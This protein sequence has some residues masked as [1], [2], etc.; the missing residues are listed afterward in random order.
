MLGGN[1]RQFGVVQQ[2]NH[3]GDV[4]AALHGAQQFDGARLADQ[5]GAGFALGDGREETGLDVSGLIHTGR[6]AVGDQ[7]NQEGFF[8]SRWVF[9]QL[10]Q[11]CGLFGVQ[12]LGHDA[13][14]GTLFNMFAIGYKHSFYPHQW[15]RWVRNA[16]P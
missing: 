11:A 3:G 1:S 10:D 14:S 5:R 9:Q 13:L 6:N 2:L 7:V 16:H 4:V 15:S 12:R 8:A